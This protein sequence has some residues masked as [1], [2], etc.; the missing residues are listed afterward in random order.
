MKDGPNGAFAAAL[1]ACLGAGGAA[2]VAQP[3]QGQAVSEDDGYCDWAE[4]AAA[5]Q[6]ALLWSPEVFGS[7]GYLDQTGL[8]AVPDSTGNDLRVTAGVR[9]SLS[10]LY[11]GAVTRARAEADCVRHQNLGQLEQDTSY[12][13]LQ[14]RARVLAK[15]LPKAKELLDT[16]T[17]DFEQRQ[18]SLQ[19][20]TATR[21]R[22]DG[23]RALAAETQRQLGEAQPA[24]AT[25]FAGSLQSYYAADADV[26]HAESR[27]RWADAW[28]VSL[29]VGYDRFIDDQTEDSP[30]FALASISFNI[31]ALF[32]GAPNERA[33]A[34][35]ARF[36][37]QERTA[38]NATALRRLRATARAE[39][40]REQETAALVA[41][42]EKQLAELEGLNS[43]N[44]RRYSETVWFE[45]V[46]VKAEHEYLRA[47]LVSLAEI[48][49]NEPE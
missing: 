26:E 32:Q 45:W 40:R 28:D 1:L 37:R 2:A 35:R 18:S 16:A 8:T 33:A 22:V 36:V 46:K 9:Y 21:L 29:R 14:A 31:G 49:R 20:L 23:L 15:A 7:F 12:R 48:L 17:R 10:N 6:S 5:A 38:Q 3:A 27:L 30:V 24:T 13:A 44:S 4:G 39:K 41:D 25:P 43:V 47:H 42:L 34:G 11:R 19:E